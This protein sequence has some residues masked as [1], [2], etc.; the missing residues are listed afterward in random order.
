MIISIIS[1]PARA[2]GI[3]VNKYNPKVIFDMVTTFHNEN[4]LANS[5]NISQNTPCLWLLFSFLE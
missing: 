1:Y 4:A 5:L 3:I 2:C